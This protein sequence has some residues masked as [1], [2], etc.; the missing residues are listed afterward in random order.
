MGNVLM[1]PPFSTYILEDGPPIFEVRAKDGKCWRIWIDGRI[2]GFDGGIVAFN[3]IFPLFSQYLNALERRAADCLCNTGFDEHRI[4]WLSVIPENLL[5]IHGSPW[6]MD[7][8]TAAAMEYPPG[9]EMLRDEGG[10]IKIKLN[11][12]LRHCPD[13]QGT[14]NR[15]IAS[16]R[17]QA[18]L[19]LPS[20]VG[21]EGFEPPYGLD[22]EATSP[23]SDNAS[24]CKS[25]Y[26]GPVRIVRIGSAR[27]DDPGL[28]ADTREENQE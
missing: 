16:R 9:T 27:S 3:G 17:Q 19:R 15:A 14:L 28:P 21:L 20:R 25:G 26:V 12:H 6:V 24:E 11:G 18:L 5:E 10:Q 23:R 22:P 7:E 4:T 13:H 2:E 8:R 1:P